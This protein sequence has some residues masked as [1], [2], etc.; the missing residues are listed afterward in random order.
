[1]QPDAR[2]LEDQPHLPLTMAGAEE[3]LSPNVA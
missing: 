2:G 3:R 1:V